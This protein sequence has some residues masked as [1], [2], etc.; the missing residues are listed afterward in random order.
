M[1]WL[2][3]L[4]LPLQSEGFVA[5]VQSMG[6]AGTAKAYPLDCLAGA[7]NPA[8]MPLIG[9]RIDLGGIWVMNTGHLKAHKRENIPFPFSSRGQR[10][11]IL[12]EFGINGVWWCRESLW[13]LGL[14]SYP[15]N[16]QKR[17]FGSCFREIKSH[18]SYILYT[19]APV[20]AIEVGGCFSLGLSVDWQIAQLKVDR[21]KKLVQN[22]SF[23]NANKSSYSHGVT[24]TAG[25]RWQILNWLAL[26]A[27]YQPRCRM[28]KFKRKN[29]FPYQGRLDVPE[30]F[31]AGLALNPLERLTLC[32][33]VERINWRK[34]HILK[35]S[36]FH[37]FHLRQSREQNRF[38]DQFE[39]R[40]GV[41]YQLKDCLSLRGGYIHATSPLKNR[42]S[43]L[44][45]LNLDTVGKYVTV[46]MTYSGCLHEFS[47]F[48]A[49]GF[50][51]SER[52]SLL[53]IAYS[54]LY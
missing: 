8:G 28:S 48:Y 20:L 24:V 11:Y 37:F 31:G 50:R 3:F 45:T 38:K 22:S 19:I 36:L 52:K 7:Y 35:N 18:P 9:D 12:G 53:G 23:A 1:F 26:G 39:C 46:G 15:R 21:H 6:M 4:L 30:R 47:G 33:D 14:I 10:N 27:S 17:H 2:L 16:F 54:W 43:I 25:F 40:F 29:S 5:S 13:S 49:Y 42:E 44:D 41:E 51:K 34:S 32:L